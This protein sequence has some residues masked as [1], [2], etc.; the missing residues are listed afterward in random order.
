MARAGLVGTT[1]DQLGPLGTF[2]L[3][4]TPQK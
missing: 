1:W 3:I 4:E 2:G